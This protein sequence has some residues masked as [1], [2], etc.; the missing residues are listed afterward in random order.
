MS[1]YFDVIIAGGSI[2][3]L[4]AAREIAA[5]GN[6][7]VVVLEEDP[8]IG[9]PQHCGGLVSMD[10]IKNLGVIPAAKMIE[11]KIRQARISSPS[12]SL[13]LNTEGQKVI[14]LDRRL[15]DKQVAL[16]AQRNGVEIRTR[17]S[18]RSFSEKR[19]TVDHNQPDFSQI[20]KTS[21]GDFGCRFFIDARGVTSIIQNKRHGILQSAQYEVYASWIENDTVE[22][23]FDSDKYPGFFAWIIPTGDGVGKVGVAGKGINA[24]TALTSY[25]DSKGEKYSVVRKV[26]APIWVSGPIENFISDRRRV[27]IGDAAGQTKPTT[28]GGIYTC[29]MGGILAGRAISKAFEENDINMLLDYQQSWLAIFQDEFNKMLLARRILERVDNKALDELFHSVSESRLREICRIGEFDFHTAAL[30]KIF[31]SRQGIKIMKSILGNEIRRL[32][33]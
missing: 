8:E 10:G 19:L 33:I 12:Y 14:A 26:D 16:Q 28:A 32:L 3:G 20:I 31:A 13:D 27:I 29:G 18:V 17:C 4:L 7:S 25:M 11:S 6:R 5:Q 30:T 24:A 9:T 21:E 23:Q 2:S 15:L 1:D 22:V